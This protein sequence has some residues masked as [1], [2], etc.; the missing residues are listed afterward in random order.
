MN[1]P[2]PHSEFKSIL[3]NLVGLCFKLS[4]ELED[5]AQIVENLLGKNKALG[6]TLKHPLHKLSVV[7]ALGTVARSETQVI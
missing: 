2:G 3:G 6:S 7:P 5:E 4:K 1:G